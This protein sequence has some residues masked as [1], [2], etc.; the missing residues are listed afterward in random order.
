VLHPCDPLGD[1][2]ARVETNLANLMAK[3]AVYFH[4]LDTL[5]LFSTDFERN[6]PVVAVLNVVNVMVNVDTRTAREQLDCCCRR[7]G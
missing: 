7:H 1:D 3:I 4:S 2:L 6:D 5:G